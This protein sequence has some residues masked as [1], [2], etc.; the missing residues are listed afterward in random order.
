MGVLL[1]LQLVHPAFLLTDIPDDGGGLAP[2]G[3]REVE[4]PREDPAV[5][6]VGAAVA[7]RM[8]DHLVAR[9]LRD[10]LVGDA[11]AVRVDDQR[12]AVLVLQPLVALDALLGVVLGFAFLPDDLR[13]ADAAARIRQRSEEPTSELQYPMRN[14]Y[15]VLCL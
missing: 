4:H 6:R 12:A 2:V 8:D 10:E 5:G 13:A 9:R 3:G 1:A 15:A 7:H 11:R 14:S